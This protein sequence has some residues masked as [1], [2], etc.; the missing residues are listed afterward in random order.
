MR[1]RAL[2]SS[3]AR[4]DSST[5]ARVSQVSRLDW[6]QSDGAGRTLVVELPEAPIRIVGAG[7]SPCVPT[8]PF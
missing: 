7:T 6:D 4:R 1:L 2:N 3:F 8:A 5:R